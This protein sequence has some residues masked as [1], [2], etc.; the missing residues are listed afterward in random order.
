MNAMRSSLLV[1]A[2]SALFGAFLAIGSGASAAPPAAPPPHTDTAVFAGGCFWGMELVFESLKGV[3]SVVSGYS[4]G[5]KATANYEAVSTGGTGHAESV[6]ITYDPAVISYRRL[7]DVYFRVAHDPTELDRQGPDEGTQYRSA[8]FYSGERQKQTAL[9]SMRDL[10]AAKAFPR[11]I[12]TQVVPLRGFYAAESYHQHFAAKNPT[13]P[14]IVYND[15]PKAVE[16]RAHFPQ[17][18]KPAN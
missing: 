10:T 11:P 13:Y 17:L 14:Y 16:L 7:L 18:V 2:A 5:A 8:I 6:E 3:T 12:V 15:A 1:R 9:E 4:G